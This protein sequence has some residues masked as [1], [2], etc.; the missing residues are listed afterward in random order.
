MP[1]SV[2]IN[3]DLRHRVLFLIRYAFRVNVKIAVFETNGE[4]DFTRHC[5]V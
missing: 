3:V 5:T 1:C 4:F 2:S